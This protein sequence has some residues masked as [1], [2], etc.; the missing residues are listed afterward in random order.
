MKAI[1]V[2]LALIQ[3]YPSCSTEESKVVQH[4]AIQKI[5]PQDTI[6]FKKQIQPIFVN[7]CSPCHFPGGKMYSRLPFDA[8]ETLVNNDSVILRRIKDESEKSL[9]TK[10]IEEK[11][12][13]KKSTVD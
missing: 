9:L 13:R 12:S 7:R 4:S 5:P 2:I 1:I 11:K 6:D 10:Y 8:G 3:V